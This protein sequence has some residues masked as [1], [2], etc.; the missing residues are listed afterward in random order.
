MSR[1]VECLLLLT[2]AGATSAIPAAAEGIKVGAVEFATACSMSETMLIGVFAATVT[3]A[4]PLLLVPATWL[5]LDRTRL[6]LAL[7]AAGEKPSVV[8]I[9]GWNVQQIRYCAALFG[10]GMAGLAG[11]FLSIAYLSTW[12]EGMVAGQ[13]WVPLALV[14]FGGWRPVRVLLGAY[15]FGFSY[16]LVFQVQLFGGIFRSISVHILQMT[17]YL[18][19]IIVMTLMAGRSRRDRAPAALAVPY[20]RE[21]RS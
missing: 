11:A 17:P 5:L 13:G 6:G 21:E 16:I 12:A 18:L 1:Y 2:L 10:A 19:T 15:L 7:R 8:D 20:V 4:T 9:A 3:A 14:V